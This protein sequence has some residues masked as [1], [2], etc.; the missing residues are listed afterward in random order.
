MKLFYSPGACSLGIHLLLEEIGKPYSLSLVDLKS[1]AQYAPDY[2]KLNPKSKVPALLRDDDTLLTEYPAIAMWLAKSNPDKKLLPAD[3]EG[4]VRTLELVD[5]VVATLH[6]QGFSRLFRPDKFSSIESE[7]EAVRAAGRE[8]IAKGLE[9]VSKQI[10][11][12]SY[13]IGDHFT[14]ADSALFYLLFWVI[15][16]FKIEVPANIKTY[17]EGLKA[18]PA[19]RKVLADEGFGG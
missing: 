2:V 4:E 5:Y 14:I 11:D 19:A 10:G 16:L 8:I 1:G 13:A 17:F 9:H 6:M 3:L 18:R 12:R 15:D 7:Q